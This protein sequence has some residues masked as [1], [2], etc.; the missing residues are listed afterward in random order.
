M[1]V[2]GGQLAVLE[3]ALPRW[4]LLRAIY[5][6][7][8]RQLLPRVGRLISRDPAAYTYLPTS[9][10]QFP[11]RDGFLARME[12]AGLAAGAWQDLAA[13]VVCLYTA[14]RST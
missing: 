10:L 11:Q 1:L 14:R 8:F 4:R 3:F 5:L 6:F 12:A 13:G 7:Y 2:P 9:V